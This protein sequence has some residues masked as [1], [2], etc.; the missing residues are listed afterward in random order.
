VIKV[1]IVD[2]H[3]VYRRGLELM[4]GDADGIELVGSAAS[5]RDAIELARASAPDVVLMDLSMPGVDGYEA[6]RRITGSTH[7]PNVL[8]LTMFDDDRSLA[9]AL[10]AGAQGYLVKGADLD[11]ITAA[12]RT[13]AGGE[14]VFGR[15]LAER[16]LSHVARGID[17][18][19]T[20]F[21]ELTDREREV[22]ELVASGLANPAIA[23]ELS[24]SLKTVRNH[25]SNVFTKLQ[26]P[27]RASAIVTARRA[28]YGR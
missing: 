21:P 28:G 14:V 16:V 26:V 12:I 17:T 19:P 25:V 10:D 22:L 6:T 23:H 4:L 5:G 7:R 13:A 3:P 9:A 2:D 15:E 18:A 20:S 27:D 1:L 11:E 24:I 8:V